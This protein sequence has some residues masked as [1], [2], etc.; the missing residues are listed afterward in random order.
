MNLKDTLEVAGRTDKGRVRSSNEDYIGEEL[1]IGVVALADGMGGYR[2]GEIASAIA[3][4]T[5][6]DELRQAI[7]G[8][9]PGEI[10]ESTGYSRQS[11]AAREAVV[12]ANQTIYQ[13]SRSQAQFQGMGTTIVLGI[14][15]NNKITVAHVGDSRMYRFRDDELKTITVDHTLLQELIDRGLYT[16]EEARE[17]LNKN[18]VTRALGIESTVAVDIHEDAVYPGDIFILCSDGLNDMVEDEEIKA[19]LKAFDGN[20]GETADRLIEK[21]NERG[22]KDNV[23]ALLIHALKAF[24]DKPS[25]RSKLTRWFT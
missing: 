24:P 14:F 11:I 18:L 23:S 21:A 5:I 8:I 16:P 4:N 22:G 2:G 13:T 15:H 3:I 10:D 6:L 9:G 17:S 1:E 12:K 19:A 25:W 7:P 20:L